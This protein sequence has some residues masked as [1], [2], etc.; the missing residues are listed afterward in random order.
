MN[1]ISASFCAAD[2]PPRDQSSQMRA[3]VVPSKASLSSPVEPGPHSGAPP[4][5]VVLEAEVLTRDDEVAPLPP[6]PA[7][8]PLALNPSPQAAS[9]TTTIPRTRKLMRRCYRA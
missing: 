1:T 7:P 3:S 9:E 6:A 5:P 8:S 2:A 4:V